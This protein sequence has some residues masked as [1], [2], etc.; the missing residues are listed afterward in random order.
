MLKAIL[1]QV[2]DHKDLFVESNVA[3]SSHAFQLTLG[4]N[5][6]IFMADGFDQYDSGMVGDQ[7]VTVQPT[8][9]DQLN[10][11]VVGLTSRAWS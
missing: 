7:L 11:R 8:N 2:E 10:G 9:S 3:I 1:S 5:I 6:H 4:R